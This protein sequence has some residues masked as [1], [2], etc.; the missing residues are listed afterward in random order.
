MKAIIRLT[1]GDQRLR[2]RRRG[3]RTYGRVPE[4]EFVPW[5]LDAYVMTRGQRACMVHA[6]VPS[7]HACIYAYACQDPYGDKQGEVQVFV[8]SHKLNSASLHQPLQQLHVIEFHGVPRRCC[9]RS[10]KRSKLH[11]P[12]KCDYDD[13]TCRSTRTRRTT[14]ADMADIPACTGS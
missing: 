14:Q 11:Q 2:Q 8:I 9:R 4:P 5:L 3:R 7:T 12:C 6:S 13:T 10:P 1:Q